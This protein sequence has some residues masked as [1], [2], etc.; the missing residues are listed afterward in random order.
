MSEESK[1]LAVVTIDH[2]PKEMVAVAQEVAVA[3]NPIVE[4]TAVNIHGKKYIQV[5]GWQT[6][7]N[8][9]G[10]VLSARD[11]ERIDGGIRSIG[12][13]RR[14]R[15][16]LV[17]ATGEGFVGDDEKTWGSRDEYA[18]RAM[19]Q[20]RAMSRAGRSAFAYVVVL[21]DGGYSPT[22]AEEMNGDYSPETPASSPKSQ[23]QSQSA[24]GIEADRQALWSKI[25]KYTGGNESR[26]ADVLK[27]ITSSPATSK[28][29]G[30]E[31]FSSI[32]GMKYDWQFDNANE[33]LNILMEEGGND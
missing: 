6:I 7:A 30:F 22:P 1:E 14:V 31:G 8:A 15:D 16:G 24:D 17:I 4:K 13:V 18:K 33:K 27:N 9:H 21:M 32:G 25:L 29:K 5:E 20:T 11:V 3:C 23:N 28:K 26:A 19:A 10:C 2:T 12:E